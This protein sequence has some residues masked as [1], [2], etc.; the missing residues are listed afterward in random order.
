MSSG[1][2]NNGAANGLWKDDANWSGATYPQAAGEDATFDAT[3]T[4]DCSIVGAL[5]CGIIDLDTGY[6][7]TLDSDSAVTCDGLLITDAGATYTPG[8]NTITV[9]GDLIVNA[10]ATI[11][12]AATI[13]IM[14]TAANLS[15]GAQTL[16]DLRMSAAITLTG[17][18][19]CNFW[20]LSAGSLALGAFDF[21]APSTWTLTGGTT[22][23]S[24]TGELI[25]LGSGTTTWTTNGV[26]MPRI[27]M[28][29][30]GVT[31][32]RG[33]ADDLTCKGIEME[34]S[35]DGHLLYGGNKITVSGDYLIANN[36]NVVGL[37]TTGTLEM[38]GTGNYSVPN[39]T[40]EHAP[41]TVKPTGV[42]TF[43]GGANTGGIIVDALGS[44]TDAGFS[45]LALGGK[46]IDIATTAVLVSTGDWELRGVGGTVSNPGSG[47]PFDKLLIDSTATSSSL[48]GTTYTKDFTVEAS[49][50]FAMGA[51]NMLV[52]G[53]F[54]N[55]GT[56]SNASG[57]LTFNG[58][59]GTPTIDSG[60]DALGD[61]TIGSTLGIT[62]TLAA[63]MIATD[64]VTSASS[65]FDMSTFNLNL[66]G[67]FNNSTLSIF[68]NAAGADLIFDAT[69]GDHN[70]TTGSDSM[71][72]VRIETTGGADI[73]LQD[74]MDCT[75]VVL[76]PSAEFTDNGNNVTAT[77]GGVNISSTG[78]LNSTATWQMDASN[79]LT[80]SGAGNGFGAFIVNG[81]TVSQS[82]DVHVNGALT[83][84]VTKSLARSTYDLF[85]GGDF[86]N[87]GTYT[88]GSGTLE[89]D[90][91]SNKDLTSGGD[92]LGNI[93]M[94]GSPAGVL[95][96]LDNLTTTGTLEA[97][98][99]SF[100]VGTFDLS[101]AGLASVT[102]TAQIAAGLGGTHTLS[103]GITTT[104]GT[105]NGGG[106]TWD[107]NGD[108]TI[109][110][111]VFLGST[112]T[113]N[114]SENWVKTGGSFTD[115]TGVYVFDASVGAKTIANNGLVVFDT[116][117]IS[118]SGSGT[119]SLAD[120][121]TRV[122]NTFTVSSGATF[123]DAG[124]LHTLRGDVDIHSA[125]TATFTGTTQLGQV[126][127]KNISNPTAANGFFDL[128]LI[129][130][131]VVTQIGDVHVKN[132]FDVT[133]VGADWVR[134]TFALN[135]AGSFT[136]AGTYTKG[137]GLLTF[138]ATSG[139][140]TIDGGGDNLG[141]IDFDNG[142][143]TSMTMTGNFGCDNLDIL[144]SSKLSAGAN[145]VSC[146]ENFTVTGTFNADTGAVD[147]AGSGTSA[148]TGTIA[149]NILSSIA[150]GKTVTF[151]IATTQTIATLTLNATQVDK[152]N[153]IS[154]TP[155]SQ[156]TVIITTSAVSETFVQD[157]NNT[158][159]NVL[160][161][162]GSD[163]GNNIGF[164][165]A[166][167]KASFISDGAEYVDFGK[168]AT[169]ITH[170][171]ADVLMRIRFKTSSFSTSRRTIAA[172]DNTTASQEDQIGFD[173]IESTDGTNPNKINFKLGNSGSVASIFSNS[174][175][176][177]STFTDLI[178]VRWMANLYGF[179]NGI[180]QTDTVA[181]VQSLADNANGSFQIARLARSGGTQGFD[182]NT[183]DAHFTGAPLTAAITTLAQLDA[184]MLKVSTC[185]FL[186]DPADV[187]G[188]TPS[189]GYWPVGRLD[190][191]P[192]ATDQSANSNDGTYT[193]A[194]VGDLENDIPSP[195]PVCSI[196]NVGEQ[197]SR[198]RAFRYNRFF[199]NT[200][201]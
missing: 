118:T 49:G 94:N 169:L 164:S 120:A 76:T 182:G 119:L 197:L 51:N 61:V 21:T 88:A 117:T 193:S 93:K 183:M 30:M 24:T 81:N 156:A 85:V 98:Q 43:T 3:S 179:V 9:K 55:S 154:D 139:V 157:L 124:F 110:S 111:G 13:W 80:N 105:F 82:G 113:Y 168:V 96:M 106:G 166:L 148:I 174:A 66:S 27:R 194:E 52:S 65:R 146:N 114:M 149:F 122:Q 201:L 23:T 69:S 95:N 152:I 42:V 107:I 180:R 29:D 145:T 153:I 33:P 97:A 14:D 40:G 70:F 104:L 200:R 178:L 38:T 53:I 87:S 83:I 67:S 44:V 77:A 162:D 126:A 116:L 58:S 137:A 39:G 100:N 127:A 11:T 34:A 22:V 125:S 99:G 7:G 32:D 92:D 143:S 4:A 54:L 198:G 102:G 184:L 26:S 112:G 35:V 151:P 103:S 46:N 90:P 129:G 12:G 172:Y 45:M 79:N 189:L 192:T 142:S 133:H 195:G 175:V 74:A 147:F 173:I 138:D 121:N 89:F 16:F 132:D 50:V 91:T 101:V 15:N 109:N 57:T 1:T 10:S 41:V 37:G 199:R 131:A 36:I 8:V 68:T 20:T 59:T 163:G 140:H 48:A 56:F 167:S 191:F 186:M 134:S 185:G 5:T 170:G 160:V 28:K 196:N 86:T 63:N 123:L 161:I 128:N 25:V 135:V 159:T 141:D 31:A 187:P 171:T 190:V 115:G 75:S 108:V 176:T 47:N 62:H 165:F 73:V 19:K 136:N 155:A 64:F 158:G 130:Q 188:V 71:G 181:S 84:N 2:W 17:D 144:A 60:G 177:L 6:T 18:S 78:T 150:P 72:R